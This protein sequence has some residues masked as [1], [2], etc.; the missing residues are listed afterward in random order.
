MKKFESPAIE[1]IAFD[2][3][4]IITVSSGGIDSE[5]IPG[6]G[7]PGVCSFDDATIWSDN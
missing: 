1:I 7:I 3:M 4:D 6:G 2:C 5:Q